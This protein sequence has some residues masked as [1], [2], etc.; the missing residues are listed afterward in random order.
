MK[1]FIIIGII[2]AFVIGL[3]AWAINTYTTVRNEGTRTELAVTA[4]Y[5]AMQSSY[6]QDR[7]AFTDQIGIA[8]EKRDALDK[9]LTDAVSG[10]YNKPGSPQVDNGK[11]FS[12]ITEAYPD[13]KGLDIYDKI[14]DFVGKMR[15]K[16]AQDQAQISE[17]IKD[18]NTWRQ[19]GSFL[20]PTF[21]KWAGFP[22]DALEL[23]VG[24]KVYRGQEA[25]DKM[26]RPIV[27]ND[28]NVI[29]DSGE[30]QPALTPE[31]K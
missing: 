20:H 5:K 28:T 18:Y 25:L 8:R 22:S 7:L 15:N 14:L 13:L 10:R 24:D 26:A 23:V 17:L 27:G 1:K 6:G 2:A 9:I 4:K 3:G 16:F 12:A 30:D 29:F 21:V 19:T 11:F 31:K